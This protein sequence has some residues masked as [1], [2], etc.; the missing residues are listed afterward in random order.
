MY[1]KLKEDVLEIGRRIY[2]KGF[3]ASNDGNISIR[4]K[5]DLYLMTPTCRSKGFLKME[6]VL[7]ISG[8]G[9]VIEG[10][11]KPSSEFPMHLD[12]YKTRKEINAILHTHP[13]YATGFAVSNIPLTDPVLPEV[14]VALGEIPIAEYATPSTKELAEKVVGLIKKHN[15]VLL[16]NH[17]LV[18]VGSDVFKAYFYT[19]TVELF[20]KI[21]FI[22]RMLGNTNKIPA[23]DVKKLIAIRSKYDFDKIPE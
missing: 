5:D 17:G 10:D 1:E 13:P 6:E 20:A 15:A 3:I 14:V 18:T 8:A 16:Q 4:L 11:L 21:L 12:I 19:E 9:K 2:N 22:S 23:K 7:L